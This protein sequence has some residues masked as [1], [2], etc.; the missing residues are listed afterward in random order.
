MT[1]STYTLPELLHK[2][3]QG[4]L[5]SEQM[6]GYLLQHMVAFATQHADFEKRL[7]QLEQ[8]SLKAQ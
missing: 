1:L 8:P 5:T 7:R 2:W 3:K 4:Q 6:V